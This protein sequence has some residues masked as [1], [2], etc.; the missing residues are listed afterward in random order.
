M[1]TPEEYNSLSQQQQ[2]Q[3]QQPASSEPAHLH[4]ERKLSS[5]SLAGSKIHDL[6]SPT[7]HRG[8]KLRDDRSSS[9]ASI[10]S[11]SECKDER[12]III[13]RQQHEIEELKARCE[14][15]QLQLDALTGT[16]LYK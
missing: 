5:F 16:K 1:L 2:Q 14:A 7:K 6:L 13:E 15:L 8:R 11:S 4:S 9:M 12:D 10:G 3:Q